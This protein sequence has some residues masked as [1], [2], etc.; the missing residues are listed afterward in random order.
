L[1]IPKK[2]SQPVSPQKRNKP[3]KIF[4]ILG[5]ILIIGIVGYFYI[6]G[7]F[8]ENVLGGDMN[9]TNQSTFNSNTLSGEDVVGD[10]ERVPFRY[11]MENPRVSI[12][13]GSGDEVIGLGHNGTIAATD[14]F[15]D[16]NVNMSGNATGGFGFFKYIGSLAKRITKGWFVNLDVSQNI[17][18][19]NVTALDIYQG[20]DK[21]LTSYS[22]TDPHWSGNQSLVYLKSNPFS[23]YNTSTIP[24]YILTSDEG[25]LNVNQS[26]YWDDYDTPDDIVY[27]DLY[28]NFWDAN[29]NLGNYN[30]TVNGTTFFI[31]KKLVCIA[32]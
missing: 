4:F 11:D 23:F 21:V 17:N 12:R 32:P 31:N 2:P 14:I 19:T 18:S 15:L 25:N 13:N 7:N 30:F 1:A 28:T 9:D 5:I 3:K 27:S 10:D 22:E 24:S 26:D 6:Y 29:V 8:G 20:G 16:E